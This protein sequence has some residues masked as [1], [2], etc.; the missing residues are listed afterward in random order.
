MIRGKEGQYCG[1]HFCREH[2]REH[3][4]LNTIWFNMVMAC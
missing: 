3:N 1:V 2:N 4:D